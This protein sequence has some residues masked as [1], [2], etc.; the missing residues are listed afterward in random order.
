MD[1]I[2]IFDLKEHHGYLQMICSKLLA[3]LLIPKLNQI[4]DKPVLSQ[5]VRIRFR[6]EY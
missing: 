2:S 6:E 3:N 4:S 5:I 1:R